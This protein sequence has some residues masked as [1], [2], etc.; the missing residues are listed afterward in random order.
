MFDQ[1]WGWLFFQGRYPKRCNASLFAADVLLQP[2]F[3]SFLL[4]KRSNCAHKDHYV[5]HKCPRNNP[6]KPTSKAFYL[7]LQKYAPS[8]FEKYIT[9]VKYG[10]KEIILNLYDTAGE[11]WLPCFQTPCWTG[12]SRQKRGVGLL[13]NFKHASHVRNGVFW[14]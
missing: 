1:W 6:R 3:L 11:R 13:G 4:P 14:V 8:V 12:I 5:L 2:A 10:G 7:F 9:T